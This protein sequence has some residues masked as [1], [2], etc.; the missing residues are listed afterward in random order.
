MMLRDHKN[1]KLTEP[2]L[3]GENS[4]LAESQ[5]KGAKSPNL[6]ICLLLQDFSQ[7]WLISFFYILHEVEGP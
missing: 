6:S 2:I 1:L 4:C 5:P 7:G 3:W